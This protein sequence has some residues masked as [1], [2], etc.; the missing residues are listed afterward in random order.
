M[1]FCRTWLIHFVY[2]SLH[3]LIRSSRSILPQPPPP[4]KPCVCSSCPGVCSLSPG[5][6]L[7]LTQAHLGRPRLWWFRCGTQKRSWI[8]KYF[9]K[10]SYISAETAWYPLKK[11]SVCVCVCVCVCARACACAQLHLTYGNPLDCS[12]R[13]PPPMGFPRQEYWSR[14]PFPPPG[15]LSNPLIE[16]HLPWLLPGQASSLP[17]GHL[18]SPQRSLLDNEPLCPCGFRKGLLSLYEPW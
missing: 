3:L 13:A 18:G 16:P 1:L 7:F 10:S 12:P 8:S 5:V 11:W 15:D 6:W 4:W 2:H 9:N 17:L 14:L